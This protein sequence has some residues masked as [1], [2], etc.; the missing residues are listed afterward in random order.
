MLLVTVPGMATTPQPASAELPRQAASRPDPNASFLLSRGD[1]WRGTFH[2]MLAAA[3]EDLLSDGEPV[4]V[5]LMLEE[6]GQVLE[7]AVTAVEG[8]QLVVADGTRVDL[9]DVCR[10]EIP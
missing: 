3:L 10:L 2:L 9:D 7:V 1:A 5:S 8:G 6:S 4:Q